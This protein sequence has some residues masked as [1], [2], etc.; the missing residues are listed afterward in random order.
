MY[1]S[2]FE[3]NVCVNYHDKLNETG[4][5]AVAGAT[6][7]AELLELA[8]SLLVRYEIALRVHVELGGDEL[9]EPPLALLG[10]QL[11]LATQLVA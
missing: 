11:L 8:R 9:A 10:L 3:I 2:I 7:E 4:H 6:V 1:D 5:V